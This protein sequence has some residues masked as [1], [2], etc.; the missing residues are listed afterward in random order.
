MSSSGTART[1]DTPQPDNEFDLVES[2]SGWQLTITLTER[3]R[4]ALAAGFDGEG[5]RF[6]VRIAPNLVPGEPFEAR[7]SVRDAP[8]EEPAQPH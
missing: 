3:L 4:E 6:A 7:L 1:G 2:S 5:S 8:D